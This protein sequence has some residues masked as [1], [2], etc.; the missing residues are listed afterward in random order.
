[1]ESLIYEP[2]ETTSFLRLLNFFY[3]IKGYSGVP[4]LISI[5]M[6][7]GFE[8]FSGRTTFDWEHRF[9]VTTAA[10]ESSRLPS[11]TAS[12]N[13][14]ENACSKILKELEA[15]RNNGSQ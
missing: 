4:D 14:L 9:V 8:A 15:F 11:F 3:C 5:K 1:M 2:Y 7:G 6:Q 13:T 12:A 10:I